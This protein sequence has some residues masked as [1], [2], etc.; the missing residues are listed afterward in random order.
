V[1]GVVT[2]HGSG[3]ASPYRPE[4][5]PSIT[6]RAARVWP[7]IAPSEKLTCSYWTYG[8]R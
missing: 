6:Y 8:S 5:A 3:G 4:R 7:I 1:Q 2:R